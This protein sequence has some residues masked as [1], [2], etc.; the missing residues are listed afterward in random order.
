MFHDFDKFGSA[1]G[2]VIDDFVD[3]VESGYERTK[4]EIFESERS[5]SWGYGAAGLLSGGLFPTL[6]KLFDPTAGVGQLIIPSLE[7]GA[8]GAVYGGLDKK[9]MS[10]VGAKVSDEDV[11]FLAALGMNAVLGIARYAL[12][13]VSGSPEGGTAE[14]VLA[15]TFIG[16]LSS[17][18][19]ID[20]TRKG[21]PLTFKNFFHNWKEMTYEQGKFMLGYQIYAVKDWLN[22]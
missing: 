7:A 3:D 19:L 6:V 20:L 2:E 14:A 9:V 10:G 13:I 16:T 12:F 4:K 18:N 15:Q 17:E 5:I 21:E 1:V 11:A 22:N 8:I